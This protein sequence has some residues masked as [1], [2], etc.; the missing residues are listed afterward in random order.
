VRYYPHDGQ[1]ETLPLRSYNPDDDADDGHDSDGTEDC[2]D[3]YGDAGD[4]GG[5]GRRGGE[6]TVNLTQATR[7]TQGGGGGAGGLTQQQ[8]LTQGGGSGASLP[9]SLDSGATAAGGRTLDVFWCHRL[10]PESS[11]DSLPFWPSAEWAR[12]HRDQLGPDWKNR[13][14]GS[15]FFQ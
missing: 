4:G 13:L 3:E 2:L 15:L 9:S 6:T 7:L 8:A 1:Q 11:L 12:T 10:V 14:H 5:G